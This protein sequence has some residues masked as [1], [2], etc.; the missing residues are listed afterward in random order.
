[1]PDEVNFEKLRNI[2]AKD[3]QAALVLF[4]GTWCGDCKAFK[5]SWDNWR[6]AKTGSIFK[7]E[8]QRGGRE[9]REWTIDE[10]PTVAAYL[11]GVEKG[12]AHGKI[13]ERDL[14]RLWNLIR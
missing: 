2:V 7:V 13:S 11:D 5:P 14:D 1:M 3:G 12:R 6:N 4:S 9:W 10:I 8:I